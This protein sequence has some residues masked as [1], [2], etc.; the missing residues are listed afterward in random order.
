MP[1]AARLTSL[2]RGLFRRG[3]MEG[4]L[5]EELS[6]YAE[7]LQAQ[8]ERAGLPPEQA[9]REVLLEMGGLTHL[10]QTV[11]GAWLISACD[12]WVEDVRQAWRGLVR[13]RGLSTVAVLTFA[14]GIGA[15]TAIVGVVNA[16]LFTPPPYRDPSRLVMVWVSLPKAG[17]VRA[18][19]SGPELGDLRSR[20]V[21]FEGFGAIW[22]NSVTLDDPREPE[23][24]RI[25]L[26]TSDFFP[27]LGA[28]PA[29]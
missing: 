4:D 20:T 10:K 11:R 27:L 26:V 19:L 15:V 21:S 8:K 16:T 28:E 12:A 18:P 25:G 14:L 17:H 3:R 13:T 1:L 29:V 5:D 23:F 7:E 2:V 24:V 22:A 9:R 6:V